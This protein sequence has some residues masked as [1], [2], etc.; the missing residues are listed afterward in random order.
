[1]E[2]QP[3]DAKREIALDRP[4][5]LRLTLRFLPPGG[6]GPRSFDLRDGIAWRATRNADGPA[7]VRIVQQ[8]GR[9]VVSAWG[10]GAA[11]E[12]ETAPDL[13]GESDSREG[14]TAHHPLIAELDRQMPGMRIGRS[15][16]IVE[17]LVPTIFHQKV[18]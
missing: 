11:G 1:M 13:I 5:D 7:S 18:V 15:G 10:P 4:L 3:P 6:R 8:Q 2:P 9:V 14:F 17:S 12:V 16:K